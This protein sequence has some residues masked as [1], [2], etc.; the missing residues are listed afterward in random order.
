[1]EQINNFCKEQGF[2]S[3]FVDCLLC[4]APVVQML[5]QRFHKHFWGQFT[6][7]LEKA[8]QKSA[9]MQQTAK[10]STTQNI[11]ATLYRMVR[12]QQDVGQRF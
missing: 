5:E 6:E 4:I 12:A 1:M 7:Q 11:E 2:A 3:K 10:Q 8:Q 9:E